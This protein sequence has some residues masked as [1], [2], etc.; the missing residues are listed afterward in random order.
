M[1]EKRFSGI[2]VFQSQAITKT[3][4]NAEAYTVAAFFFFFFIVVVCLLLIVWI[5]DVTLLITVSLIYYCLQCVIVSQCNFTNGIVSPFRSSFTFQTP[6]VR[7]NVQTQNRIIDVSLAICFLGLQA[8]SWYSVSLSTGS[9][10][11]SSWNL[12]HLPVKKKKSYLS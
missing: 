3:H 12:L 9:Q 11:T 6:S 7:R 8:F 1:Q 5:E 4:W 10:H 2:D